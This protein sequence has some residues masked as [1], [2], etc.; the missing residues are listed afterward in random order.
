MTHNFGHRDGN[1]ASDQIVLAHEY[2]ATDKRIL[3]LYGPIFGMPVRGDV[4]G[5]SYLADT[6]LAMAYKSNDPITL[7]I[8]SGGGSVS[9]GLMLYDT[10]KTLSCPVYTVARTAYS[11]AAIL[12]CAGER[13]HRYI[14]P[15]SK[16][17]LHLISG[18]VSGDE[19]EIAIG[20]KEMKKAKDAMLD[21][22]QANGVTVSR[23]QLL[24]DINRDFWM[25]AQEAIDYG[26]ADHIVTKGFFGT[27]TSGG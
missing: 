7:V 17:M 3:F 15:S 24:R 6:M 10:M 19:T 14:Y 2:L 20:S 4:F 8:D 23:A 25:G 9:D 22:L 12:L 1:I 26:V 27:I 18:T 16:V 11:M 13:G 5:P 21:I